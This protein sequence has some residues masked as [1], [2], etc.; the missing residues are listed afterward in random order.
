MAALLILS[1]L[2][3]LSSAS[4]LVR[5]HFVR[6]SPSVVLTPPAIAQAC[7]ATRFQDTCVSS[8]KRSTASLPPKPGPLDIIGSAMGVSSENLATAQSM[9][10]SILESSAGHLNR[11]SHAKNC[12]EVRLI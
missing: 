3:A 5:P 8:L 10:R 12:L 1:L 4:G 11:T 2:S 6:H 9:V 7:K